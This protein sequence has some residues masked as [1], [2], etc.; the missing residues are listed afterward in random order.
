LTN[1][2]TTGIHRCARKGVDVMRGLL[3]QVP[4]R[5]A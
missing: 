1:Q 3:R 5:T 4:G 2:N